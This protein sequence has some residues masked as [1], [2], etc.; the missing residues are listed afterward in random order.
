MQYQN[1]EK[2]MNIQFKLLIIPV[3]LMVS[4]VTSSSNDNIRRIG[5]YVV[6][7]IDTNSH[8]S[9]YIESDDVI[10]A[11]FAE[12]LDSMV[13]NWYSSNIFLPDSSEFDFTI[14]LE[15]KIPDSVLI[16]RLQAIPAEVPLAYNKAVRDFIEMYT[17]R[18]RNQV[19]VML[20][21]SAFY[22]PIFEEIFDRYNLPHELKYL[23]II[24]SALN[25]V[26]VSRVGATGLWQ[27]MLGTARHLN[28]DVSTFIDDRRDVIKSTD[29]AARYLKQLYNMYGD[30]HL[31]IAAYNCG[32]GNVN[33]AIRRSGGRTDY[34]QIYYALPRETRGYV[35]AY[36]A[37]TYVMNY[38]REHQLVPRTSVISLVTDTIMV[39]DYLHLNQVSERLNMDIGL[40]R[41]LNP[42]YRRDVI[43][44]TAD[45]P[46]PLRMP[47]EYVSAFIDRSDGIFG[48]DRDTY[49]PNNSLLAPRAASSGTA[50]AANTPT[51]I[52]GK[53]RIS[54]T[55]KSGDTPGHIARWFNV[56]L[57]DLRDWNNLSRNIIRVGQR[58]T[59]YVPE[60]KKTHYE[61][62]NIMSYNAKQE[63]VGQPVQ[64]QAPA[65]AQA[66]SVAAPSSGSEYEYYT[67]KSGDNLWRIAQNFP[68]VSNQ[69]IMRFN[70]IT[71]ASNLK[72]GQ[73]LRIPKT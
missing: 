2:T 4:A 51:D 16:A 29:A 33:K 63:L 25:P 36:I 28:I 11:M 24:E 70:N 23:A 68:G 62:I 72:V 10:R 27:I 57:N 3:L 60:D 13:Q 39:N 22:F 55:V 21:L 45:K 50:A 26:A 53:A 56:H 7:A 49:F 18:K 47:M 14:P 58:L 1:I 6:T 54:Y 65:T 48:H 5:Q 73:R 12:K 69:D 30:W 66:Q 19:E 44:A 35:P 64:S 41:E 15:M 71:N 52:R 8:Q 42:I 37:A 38:Y 20:G 43:P 17:Y 67:V 34:W 46:Y 61:R 40:L 31:V 32:P 59:V 9:I